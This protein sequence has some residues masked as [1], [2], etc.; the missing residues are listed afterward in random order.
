VKKIFWLLLLMFCVSANS[1]IPFEQLMYI[2]RAIPFYHDSNHPE[3]QKYIDAIKKSQMAERMAG[4]V[5]GA[6]MLK[7]D[8]GIGFESCGTVNAF[9]SSDRHAVIICS[10][11]VEMIVKTAFSDPGVSRDIIPRV[12]DGVTWGVFFHELGHAIIGTN[13]VA[14]TG[15]EED[16]ADQFSVWFA[17]NFIDL[18][19][20][21]VLSPTV[22]LWGRLAKER[23]IPTMS[24]DEL[25]HFMA[26]E[27]SLDEQRV[28]SIACWALGAGVEGGI[29][30]A[31]LPQ[32]RAQRCPDEYARIDAAMRNNFKRYFKAKPLRGAW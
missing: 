25:R 19:Q 15:K 8:L 4:M 16:V 14:T 26:N 32:D 13:S 21:P 2:G 30:G 22:W 6:L 10:E 12:I 1:A 3:Q 9:F 27:H 24:A 7:T 23:N 11:F 18:N 17:V 29:K 28:Y 31:G 5:S 20:N